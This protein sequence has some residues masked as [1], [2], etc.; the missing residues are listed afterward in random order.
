MGGFKSMDNFLST[1]QQFSTISKTSANGTFHLKFTSLLTKM[2]TNVLLSII[3]WAATA[4]LLSKACIH[5]ITHT[6]MYTNTH[7][8]FSFLWISLIESSLYYTSGILCRYN[9]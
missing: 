9:H 3:F 8:Q 6:H 2:K 5:T 1:V 7:S 4:F